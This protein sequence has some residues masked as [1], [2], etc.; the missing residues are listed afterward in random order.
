MMRPVPRERAVKEERFL[1]L[2]SPLTGVELS[3]DG[4]GAPEL[5]RRPQQPACRRL[6]GE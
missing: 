4:G 5:R 6:T 1:H 3:L 2:E